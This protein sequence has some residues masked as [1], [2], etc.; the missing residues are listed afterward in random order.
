MAYV[1]IRTLSRTTVRNWRCVASNWTAR[2]LSDVAPPCETTNEDL[3]SAFWDPA[4]SVVVNESN[5]KPFYS[6]VLVDYSGKTAGTKEPME[7]LHIARFGHIR[8][9]SENPATEEEEE[10]ETLPKQEEEKTN[11]SSLNYIDNQFFG[12]RPQPPTEQQHASAAFSVKAANVPLDT[13]PV[14]QQY[15]YPD[16]STEAGPSRPAEKASPSAE[17]LE[18]EENEVDDQYFGKKKRQEEPE[19]VAADPT[20]IS[21]YDYLRSLKTQKVSSSA[22]IRDPTVKPS[23]TEGTDPSVTPADL[24]PNFWKMPKELIASTLKKSILY[25]KGKI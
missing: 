11:S 10:E 4:G 3:S 14:D 1:A 19:I 16:K 25:D 6:Q 18:F 8:L 17:E 9:D 7:V 13:N 2:L 20:K 24:I 12:R 5:K 22:S 21:A 15:F 23:E